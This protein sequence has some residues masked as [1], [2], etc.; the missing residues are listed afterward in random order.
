MKILLSVIFCILCFSFSN[1]QIKQ[2]KRI[3]LWDV[4]KSLENNGIWKEVKKNLENAINQ[5]DESTSE[6]VI[7]PFV[8]D[9]VDVWHCTS[10]DEGKKALISKMDKVEPG[11]SSTNICAA[12][13]KAYE[14]I[15]PD[16]VNYI[17]LMTDGQHNT[18][19][20]KN[21]FNDIYLWES[22]TLGI[23][24]Y[25]FYVMLYKEAYN[26]KL[27][28]A[29]KNQNNFWIVK[30]ADININ[31]YKLPTNLVYNIRNDKNI[32]IKI[33]GNIKRAGHM[34]IR[35]NLEENN[36]FAIKLL[37]SDLSEGM[38]SFSLIPKINI[39]EIPDPANITMNVITENAPEFT[40]L[41]P[42]QIKLLVKNEKEHALR[43]TIK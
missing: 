33:D 19:D 24:V 35:L 25:G 39:S 37:K 16:K 7:I 28:D 22:K 11:G 5:I 1:A 40:Y 2:E 17:F 30:S 23:N 26:A 41:L 18:S 10:T 31:L 13:H 8:E 4:T 15:D 14:L 3:Y 34:Q 6:I 43:V 29:I 9:I 27:E 42:S 20:E 21:L 38:I 36:F 32:P 12:I